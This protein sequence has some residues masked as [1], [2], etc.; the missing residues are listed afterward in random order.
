MAGGKVDVV[1]IGAGVAGLGCAQGLREGGVKSV[2]VLEAT[3][4]LGGRVETS[5]AFSVPVDLGASWIHGAKRNPVKKLAK[6]HGLEL[7][8][9]DYGA[10]GLY[11]KQGRLGEQVTQ[12]VVELAWWLDDWAEEL[13]HKH[14]KGRPDVSLAAAMGADL[15]RRGGLKIKEPRGFDW[16]LYGMSLSEGIEVSEVTLRYYEDDAPFGGGDYLLRQGYERVVEVLADGVDVRTRSAVKKVEWGEWGVRVRLEGGEVWEAEYGVVTASLGVLKR[17]EVE[18]VPALEGEKQQAIEGLGMGLLNKVVVEFEA[19]F[20]EPKDYVIG[21]VDEPYGPWSYVV[22]LWGDTGRAILVGFVGGAR[23]MGRE[24]LGEEEEVTE[25]LGRLEE[26]FGP[27]PGVKQSR[28]TRWGQREWV[29]GAYSH[30]PVG[31]TG[32]YFDWLGR[33]LGGGRLGFGGEATCRDHPGTVHGA[34]ISGRREAAR[35]LAQL[36]RQSWG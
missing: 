29:W 27:L 32:M 4:R 19:V 15:D 24:G 20:W 9:A 26:V 25:F 16:G 23:A 13:C 22:S 3:G 18:F 7:G 8:W 5:E 35:I 28:V 14:P 30:L 31:G 10:V 1:V 36:G 21:R 2:V 17:G 34:L 6:N 33:P 11:D 12:E